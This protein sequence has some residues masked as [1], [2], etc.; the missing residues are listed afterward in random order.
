MTISETQMRVISG[1]RIATDTTWDA[2]M[3]LYAA[4]FCEWVEGDV[5]KMSPVSLQHTRLS[6]YIAN[7]LESYFELKPIGQVVEAPFVMRVPDKNIA[8]E[9]DIQVILNS[10][11]HE[12]TATAMLGPAD[13]CIEIVSTESVQRD[14][15]EKLTDYEQAGVTEYWIIDPLRNECRFYRLGEINEKTLY[16]PQSIDEEGSYITP[17]L[18][19]LRLSIVPLWNEK[20][21]GPIAIV[22]QVRQ[23]LTKDDDKDDDSSM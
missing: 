15:G 7:L 14:H 8:R 5:Y 19:G 12:L 10:N 3:E 9:P 18:P 11:P 16:V 17:Q 21:P 22:E 1:Q 23:M 20:L 6:R 13:I 2:Y 4:Q